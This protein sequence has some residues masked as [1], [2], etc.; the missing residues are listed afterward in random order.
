MTNCT[1]ERAIDF[2]PLD[3]VAPGPIDGL[4]GNKTRRA[5]KLF[6]RDEK[7]PVTGEISDSLLRSLQKSIDTLE[8]LSI[9]STTTKMKPSQVLPSAAQRVNPDPVDSTPSHEETELTV[10]PRE[11]ETVLPQSAG[12]TLNAIIVKSRSTDQDVTLASA[13]PKLVDPPP[14][15]YASRLKTAV[16]GAPKTGYSTQGTLTDFVNTTSASPAEQDPIPDRKLAASA[17]PY[18]LTID[19][20][21]FTL[22]PEAEAIPVDKA[23]VPS[24]YLRTALKPEWDFAHDWHHVPWSGTYADIS[25]NVTRVKSNIYR[26]YQTASR[27]NRYL[28][29]ATHSWGG[30][31]AYRAIFELYEER[32]IPVGAI[33]VL[34]TMGSPLNAQYADMKNVAANYGRWSGSQVLTEPVKAWLNYW[35]EEDDFSG[36]ISGITNTELPYTYEMEVFPHN[37]YHQT[38]QFRKA[39]EWDVKTSL[40]NLDMNLAEVQLEPDTAGPSSNPDFKGSASLKAARSSQTQ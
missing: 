26:I 40:Q 17:Q 3:C 1:S 27:E 25:K 21:D 13:G 15:T 4:Y 10:Q 11:S 29:V 14:P 18:L 7:L 38:E 22:I 24:S 33:D 19:G 34:I 35:I 16:A 32:K 31:L 37:A 5:I 9:A 2:L 20:I 36:S 12:G 39:I 23:S 8:N 28:V 30:V 6:Q